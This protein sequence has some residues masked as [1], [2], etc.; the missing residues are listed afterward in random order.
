M[1]RF[2]A[3]LALGL[4]IAGSFLPGRAEA[5]REI[6]RYEVDHPKFGS[7]GTYT[8]VVERNGDK[9]QVN[10]ELHVAVRILGITLYRQDAQRVETWEQGRL[11]GFQGITVTNGERLEIKGEAREDGFSIVTPEGKTL[12]PV[13]VR[14]T[15]PWTGKMMDATHL[16]STRSGR[17]ENVHITGGREEDVDVHGHMMRLRHFEIHGPRRQVVW[18]DDH[19]IAVF[20][21][22]ESNG[23]LVDFIL[24]EQT[25]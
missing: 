4:F 16:M 1:K 22:A 24:T 11:T 21:Q 9:V 13:D 7:I 5:A 8:N 14:P 6:Y 20:F 2:A 18:L 10:T 15:N 25:G 3:Y 19:D 17:V 23:T 12:A